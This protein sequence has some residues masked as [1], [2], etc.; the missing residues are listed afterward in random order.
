MPVPTDQ[1][2]DTRLERQRHEIVVLRIIR[3]YPW[4]VGRVVQEGPLVRE[5][6]GKRLTPPRLY[7]VLAADLGVNQRLADLSHQPR[8]DDELELPLA[9]RVEELCRSTC[10]R[11]DARDQAVGVDDQPDGSGLSSIPAADLVNNLRGEVQGLL[12]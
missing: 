10:R 2:V 11:Q 12:L 6:R 1:G 8:A 3:D 7:A 9:P 5:P 4:W